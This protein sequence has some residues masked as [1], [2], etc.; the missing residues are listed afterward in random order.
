V[1]VDVLAGDRPEDV[2]V[3]LAAD[4]VSDPGAL[5]S[6]VVRPRAGFGDRE[7]YETVCEKAAALLH[8]LLDNHPFVD[9]NKRVAVFV[10][11]AFLR[12]NGLRLDLDQGEAFTHV[13]ALFERG[14]FRRQE[15]RPWLELHAHPSADG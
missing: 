15:L 6:A 2:L 5:E 11:Y 13:M 10:T 7:F 14:R 8:S 12:M 3:Y 9:G 1:V 4:A